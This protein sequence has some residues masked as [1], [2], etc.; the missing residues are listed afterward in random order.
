MLC[1]HGVSTLPIFPCPSQLS[2]LLLGAPA[3]TETG[4]VAVSNE[5]RVLHPEPPRTK[6]GA[7]AKIKDGSL[8]SNSTNQIVR[9]V[10]NNRLPQSDSI[11]CSWFSTKGSSSDRDA[12][13][14]C[15]KGKHATLVGRIRILAR[16]HPRP[17]ILHQPE[18]HRLYML[19]KLLSCPSGPIPSQNTLCIQFL[20][21]ALPVCAP[22]KERESGPNQV[23][24]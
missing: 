18:H 13:T 12:E 14:K 3:E 21:W 6:S 11:R 5:N 16:F 10:V 1:T 9:T 24:Y 2:T 8:G 17:T 7:S 23:C 19:L 20:S 22:P 15:A 4:G